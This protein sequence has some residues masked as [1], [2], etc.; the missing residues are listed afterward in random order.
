MRIGNFLY[1][2]YNIFLSKFDHQLSDSTTTAL[3]E[4]DWLY[5]PASRQI[6]HP[7]FLSRPQREA[8][9][10]RIGNWAICHHLR[11]LKQQTRQLTYNLWQSHAITSQKSDHLSDLKWGMAKEMSDNTP[12]LCGRVL[13]TEQ[14]V[15]HWP[16]LNAYY[17]LTHVCNSIMTKHTYNIYVKSGENSLFVN[18]N[19]YMPMPQWDSM[20]ES[21]VGLLCMVKQ[22]VNCI[23]CRIQLVCMSCLVF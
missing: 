5:I 14:I 17:D 15:D 22:Y 23:I 3:S 7:N 20:S 1:I 19:K 9:Q 11:Q 10:K 4:L 2:L 8:M 13:D 21:L 16:T 18:L 6:Q 12:F